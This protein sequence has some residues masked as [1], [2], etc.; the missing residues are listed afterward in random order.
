MAA[1][2]KSEA[3]SRDEAKG[4]KVMAEKA[5][6][7]ALVSL[8]VMA[9]AVAA[10]QLAWAFTGRYEV[11]RCEP[12]IFKVDRLT[13]TTWRYYSGAPASPSARRPGGGRTLDEVL[14]DLQPSG[15]PTPSGPY[16]QKVEER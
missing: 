8:G 5:K 15:E 2:A 9:L 16:W 1:L 6:A 4:G 13:G 11:R 10:A 14:E 7:F 12:L 3:R